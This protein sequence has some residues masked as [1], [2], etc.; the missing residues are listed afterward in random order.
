VLAGLVT[1][2]KVRSL[3]IRRIDGEPAGT[4]VHADALRAAGFQDGYRGLVRRR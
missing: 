2:A 3:E 4:S 1:S